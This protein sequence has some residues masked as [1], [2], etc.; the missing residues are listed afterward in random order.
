MK[1]SFAAHADLFGQA[2]QSDGVTLGK[3]AWMRNTPS[4]VFR[5]TGALRRMPVSVSEPVPVPQGQKVFAI[6]AIVVQQVVDGTAVV[7]SDEDFR[8]LHLGQ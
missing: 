5:V 7:Q 4:G 6:G 8:R 3:D 1:T 2:L